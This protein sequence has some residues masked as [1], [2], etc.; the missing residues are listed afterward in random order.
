LSQAQAI[1]RETFPNAQQGAAQAIFAVG[2]IIGP[3]IGPLLGGLITDNASWQW[4]F[5]VN[6]P[7]GIIACVLTLLYLRN[8]AEPQK[9]DVDG[10]GLAFLAIGLGALQYVLDQGQEKD[11]FGDATIVKVTALGVVS[12]SAF[13]VW[14]L[15]V[16]KAPIVDLSVFRYASVSGGSILG[17]TLG[18]TLL[19]TLVTLPQYAQGPLGFTATLSGVLISVRALPVM[20]LTPLAAR[21]S[22]RIDPRLQVGGGFVLIGISNLMLAS[23]TTPVSDFGTFVIP[24]L[25]SGIGLSQVF[26]P[27]SLAIFGSVD[28][29]DVPKASAMFNLARQLGGSLAT[30]LLITILDRSAAAHQTRLT[31]DITAHNLPTMAYLNQNGGS[32]SAT[33]LASLTQVVQEQAQVLGYADSARASA[34]V[35]FALVPF[36][37]LLKPKRQVLGTTVKH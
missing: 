12:L 6:L 32:S 10:V 25:I 26:V 11:W 36:V 21:F 34:Y 35:T 14:E 19:G 3:T 20:I 15:R 27:L 31:A 29:I 28:P 13:F 24:L 17:F 9:L 2:A 5:F 7:L 23:V 37:L 18:V 8:P 4:C 22:D 30:A 33:A 16:A 1:L